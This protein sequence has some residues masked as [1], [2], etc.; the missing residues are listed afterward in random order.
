L[1]TRFLTQAIEIVAVLAAIQIQTGKFAGLQMRLL[2]LHVT[3]HLPLNISGT[4]YLLISNELGLV[5]PLLS[6]NALFER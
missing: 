4:Q 6:S 1:V 5:I 2:P 3:S